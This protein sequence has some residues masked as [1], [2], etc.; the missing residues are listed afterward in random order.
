MAVLKGYCEH[1]VLQAALM[2]EHAS[3]DEIEEFA[4]EWRIEKADSVSMEGDL[5]V[6]CRERFENNMRI[7]NG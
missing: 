7:I 5:C 6:Q 3:K 4:H 2:E 1:G